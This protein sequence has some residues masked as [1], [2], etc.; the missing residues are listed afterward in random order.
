MIRFYEKWKSDKEYLIQV[1]GKSPN[2]TN[3]KLEVFGKTPEEYEPGTLEFR[4]KIPFRRPIPAFTYFHVRATFFPQ[5]Y[6]PFVIESVEV[7]DKL[8][9][10]YRLF[11]SIYYN[12]SF[13]LKGIGYG[14]PEQIRNI[15]NMDKM[16]R[17]PLLKKVGN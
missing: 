13:G 3:I 11:G 14:S 5:Q 8:S 7:N 9:R 2:G 12:Y 16:L 6:E 10:N 1:L 15:E 4:G 17:N